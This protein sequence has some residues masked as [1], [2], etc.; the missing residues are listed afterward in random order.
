MHSNATQLII[1]LN[2]GKMRSLLGAVATYS[3]IAIP[4]F[5]IIGGMMLWTPLWLVVP[6]SVLL[7]CG[8]QYQLDSET[9][10]FSRRYLFFLKQS[11]WVVLNKVSAITNIERLKDQGE[12]GGEALNSRIEFY[13]N[14]GTNYTWSMLYGPS[15][16][17]ASQINLFLQSLEKSAY[18]VGHEAPLPA[19]RDGGVLSSSVT[20]GSTVWEQ[21]SSAT[22]Q[23]PAATS[24]SLNIWDSTP[25][26]PD[27]LQSDST[28]LWDH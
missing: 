23:A 10:E 5:S 3:T 28:F 16:Q 19:S 1:G 4:L 15:E 25:A 22:K 7:T 12:D 26:A 2:P 13:F 27:D 21:P 20:S 8:Q 14:D 6:L 11:P 9:D 17:Y 18:L 24:S